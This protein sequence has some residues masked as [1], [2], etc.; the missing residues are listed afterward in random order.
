MQKA[1]AT[2]MAVRV[3]QKAIE[4]LGCYGLCT[5]FPLERYHREALACMIAC[6]HRNRLL[7]RL[8]SEFGYVP[9]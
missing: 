4:I 5:D 7:L 9:A 3:T 1:F 8:A 2:D 6:D